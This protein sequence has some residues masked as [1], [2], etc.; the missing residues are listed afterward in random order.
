MYQSFIGRNGNA[1]YRKELEYLLRNGEEVYPRGK[2]TLEIQAITQIF[3]PTQRVLTV[4]GRGGNPFFN[5]AENLAIIG[6]WQDQRSWLGTFNKNYLQFFD[7]DTD[8]QTWAFYGDRLR[9]WHGHESVDQ[10]AEITKKLQVDRSSR[11]AVA[12]LWH[13]EM[14][15]LPKH[16]DYPC[17]FAVKFS[18]RD[19]LNE[20]SVAQKTDNNTHDVLHMT[21]MNRSNDIHWGLFG[22]NLSQW[23]FI[24]EVMAK[25]LGV[26]VGHQIHVSDSLHLYT[27]SP[28]S[29]ITERMAQYM[30]GF[31]I[32]DYCTPTPMFRESMLAIS[33]A[34]IDKML[35]SWK[36]YFNYHM[37]EGLHEIYDVNPVAPRYENW[38][39]LEDAYYLLL[40]YLQRKNRS[41]SLQTLTKIQD[42]ALW[43][44]A[45]EWMV[46]GKP[47]LVESA[48][49]ENECRERFGEGNYKSVFAYILSSNMLQPV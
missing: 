11:Q 10:L 6:V 16:K 37:T 31:D 8:E 5:V 44:A 24:Q 32:Y 3:E 40:A 2:R 29:E 14:D 18:V 48:D 42:P 49:V 34:S 33:W 22:V 23:S 41:L 39:F 46:R 45:V 35:Y 19:I 7:N 20:G 43:V 9:K 12:S 28:H 15:N 25:T 30:G 13:P 38:P 27:D 26:K 1:L 4:P 47:E 17:N 21:V 36:D